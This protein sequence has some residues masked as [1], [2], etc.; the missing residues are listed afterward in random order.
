MPRPHD[1]RQAHDA[2]IHSFLHSPAARAI[3]AEAKRRGFGE[4]RFDAVTSHTLLIAQSGDEKAL[5]D[6]GAW[7]SATAGMGIHA[8]PLSAYPAW[9][10]RATWDGAVPLERSEGMGE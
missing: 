5:A 2:L 10:R 4:I 6:F 9:R 3:A 7:A 1:E 8:K